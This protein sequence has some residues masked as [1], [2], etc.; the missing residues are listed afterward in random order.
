MQRPHS[1]LPALALALLA[2]VLLPACTA[3]GPRH[4][5]TWKTDPAARTA[6]TDLGAPDSVDFHGIPVRS[7]QIV[8]SEQGSP[9]GLLMSLLSADASPWIHAGI[10]SIEAG[11]PYVYE[12]NGQIRPTWSGPPTAAVG[13]GVRR[14]TLDWF[15]ANQS[16]IAIY[17][18][19]AGSDPARIV[20]FAR[21]SHARY[22]RFDPWFDLGDASRMY[23]TEF[24]ALALAAADAP[25]VR[26][27]AMNRNPS[28]RVVTEWL[29]LRAEAIIPAAALTEHGERVA[30]I[31]RDYSPAQFTAY[32][33]L[34]QELHRRFT[35]D[36]KIGN[37]LSFSP[38]TGLDFQPPVGAV[39][40]SVDVA[41]RDWDDLAEAEIDARVRQIAG[42]RLGPY[43]EE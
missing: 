4:Y 21:Q 14:M 43:P 41:A 40:R 9:L 38:F 32:F 8:V 22:I 6:V 30:L 34:K 19:P 5:T 42:E 13:G 3:P 29:Q 17:T 12:S 37:V 27:S 28:L 15:V 11:V 18:P 10:I 36:Q 2:T 31:S 24:V 7:G 16:Y 33:A 26:T 35:P 39:I 20:D 23:C 25:P 1:R